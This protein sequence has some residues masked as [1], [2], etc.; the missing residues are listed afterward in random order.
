MASW[1]GLIRT[2]SSFGS[3]AVAGFTIGIRVTADCFSLRLGERLCSFAFLG[4]GQRAATMVGQS[5]GAKK[6]DRAEKAVWRM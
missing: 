2:I 5:L 1:I 4:N 6:P 3:D